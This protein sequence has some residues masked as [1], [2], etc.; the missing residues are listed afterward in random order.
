MLCMMRLGADR[1]AVT[2]LFAQLQQA[3]H[4][5]MTAHGLSEPKYGGTLRKGKPPIQGVM[6]GNG[7][8]P[9]I[10]LAV[11]VILI[12]IMHSMDFGAVFLAAITAPNPDVR[13]HLR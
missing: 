10:W 7:M 8:G 13:F 12:G 1:E 4:A 11:S 6:Q 2:S 9:I 3:Q 5:I